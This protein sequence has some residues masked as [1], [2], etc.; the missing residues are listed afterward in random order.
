MVLWYVGWHLNLNL[1]LVN[2]Y[3]GV[4]AELQVDRWFGIVV[5]WCCVGY[6]GQ[7][8]LWCYGLPSVGGRRL[9]SPGALGFGLGAA[10]PGVLRVEGIALLTLG[11]LVLWCCLG[12]G[13]GFGDVV[14]WFFPAFAYGYGGRWVLW[15]V[16][17]P[18][19]RYFTL[20][21]QILY[22]GSGRGLRASRWW[23]WVGFPHSLCS[24]GG[25]G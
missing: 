16:P 3:C 9:F 11:A 19:T 7:G 2:W 6:G 25:W 22:A 13:G 20:Q 15:F 5:F 18:S 14:L 10:S 21:F 24:P 23:Q 8:V 4:P 1:E 17:D 12:Y